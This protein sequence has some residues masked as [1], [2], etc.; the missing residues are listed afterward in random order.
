MLLTGTYRRTV[1]DKQRITIPKKL[2]S[3]LQ[4]S[5]ANETVVAGLYIAPGTD[6]SLAIYSEKAFS[7]L[8]EKLAQGS[9]TGQDKRAFSRLFFAKAQ[10]VEMDSQGRIRVEPELFAL[11]RLEQEKEV[12][13][14]GV[15][16][17]LELWNVVGWE[18][19]EDEKQANYDQL[20]ERAFQVESATPPLTNG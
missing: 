1:D 2:R 4:E 5:P 20:A 17:H 13:M 7:Q 9:P 3:A 8:A 14:V 18:A 15:G 11:A 19:Y 6:G 10:R 12:M 16:D